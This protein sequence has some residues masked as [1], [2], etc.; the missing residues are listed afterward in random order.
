MEDIAELL[1]MMGIAVCTSCG[2]PIDIAVIQVSPSVSNNAVFFNIFLILPCIFKLASLLNLFLY[3][4]IL[5]NYEYKH[6]LSC[7]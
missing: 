2:L 1:C 6:P 3:N 5:Q 7:K 4:W